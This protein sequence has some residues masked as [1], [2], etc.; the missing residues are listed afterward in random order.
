MQSILVLIL[1]FIILNNGQGL[2]DITDLDWSIRPNDNFFMFVNGHWINRTRI[3]L[4]ETEWGGIHTMKY[5]NKYKLKKILDDLI[6]NENNEYLYA[7]HSLKR[8]LTDFYLAGLDEQAIERVGIEP[9][10]ETL[11][12]LQNIKTYQEL[13][14]FILN[15]Y[16]K[17]NQ[18][19][20]FEFDVSP[21][22]RNTSIYMVNWRVIKN[23]FFQDKE[24]F[25]SILANWYSTSRT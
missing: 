5:K 3:P 23:V 13:I 17:M 8:K 18:G 4:S 25:C 14:I 16:K 15:W 1:L 7:D 11:I 6:R 9:L 20:I 2:F 19:L 24:F 22:E 10:K 12:K 21:D